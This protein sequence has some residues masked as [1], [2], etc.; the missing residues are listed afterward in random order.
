MGGR[1]KCCRGNCDAAALTNTIAFGGVQKGPSE[2]IAGSCCPS[3]LWIGLTGTILSQTIVE[4]TTSCG[5]TPPSQWFCATARL[6]TIQFWL[7]KFSCS[8]DWFVA[9]RAEVQVGIGQASTNTCQAPG[10]WGLVSFFREKFIASIATPQ[11][12][13]FTAAD[14]YDQYASGV[15]RSEANN[16]PG[17][18]TGEIETTVSY[19]CPD[20]FNPNGNPIITI[21]INF[22]ANNFSFELT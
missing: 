16:C 8:D 17:A 5:G 20:I 9:M 2:W 11:T 14:H 12:I 4:N 19:G 10:S 6:A 7:S 15:C 3:G 13:T 22:L 21:P 1:R 18:Y